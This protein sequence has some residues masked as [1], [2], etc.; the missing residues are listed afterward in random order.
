MQIFR[1][2]IYL[3]ADFEHFIFVNLLK[4]KSLSDK[5]CFNT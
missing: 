3:V 4:I 1:I 2:Y 5:R